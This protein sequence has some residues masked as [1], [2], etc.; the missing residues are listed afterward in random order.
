ML[1]FQNLYGLHIVLVLQLN[2]R[3]RCI[4]DT[5]VNLFVQNYSLCHKHFQ[6]L[7]KTGFSA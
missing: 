7:D 5:G 4:N 2:E 1:Q 3:T 6:Q